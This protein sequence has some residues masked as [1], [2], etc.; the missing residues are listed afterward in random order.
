MCHYGKN[1]PLI[2]VSLAF[3]QNMHL[4]TTVPVLP[5]TKLKSGKCVGNCPKHETNE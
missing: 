3:A 5:D 2:K 1:K 4:M